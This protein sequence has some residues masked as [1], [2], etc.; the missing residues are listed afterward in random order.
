MR[1]LRTLND[2]SITEINYL[3]TQAEKPIAPLN[4]F[5]TAANLFFEASTR[6]KYSFE[7]AEAKL[8]IHK[9]DFAAQASSLEK[10]ESLYDTLKTF[11][12]FGTDLLVIRH[13]Q[14][15]YYQELEGLNIPIINAGDGAGDHPT[16]SLL[17]LL[18]M[19]QEFG[20][21]LGLHV[22]IAGDILHSR[23]ANTNAK[24]LE[25][26]GA[27]VSYAGPAE[28]MP[29]HISAKQL[30][31]M[32][33]AVK[34]ADVMM[35][36]RIQT[37]RHDGKAFWSKQSYHNRFGLT[38]ER[39]QKMLPHAIIMHPAPV[40]R[41]VELADSLVEAERSRIFKQ[42]QNGVLVRQSVLKYLLETKGA[43]RYEN[44]V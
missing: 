17:D 44:I 34:Q 12:S 9:F 3:L 31:T 19:K 18:T 36:L 42:V 1:Q 40:N 27:R 29:P 20:T 28:W 7:M 2:L 26:L 5:Y 22:V 15:R 33:E 23:V 8:G 39:E 21:L 6:T 43:K 11:E 13:P 16:Q 10:G 41:G 38:E 32:D 37:E 35:M 30:L 4:G 25:Q 24:I 14:A